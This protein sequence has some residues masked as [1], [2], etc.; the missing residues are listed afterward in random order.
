M[1]KIILVVTFFCIATIVAY[2]QTY[3]MP[4]PKTD[5]GAI[6]SQQIMPTRNYNGTVYEPFSTSTPSEQS[7]VGSSY[8]P[9]DTPGGPRKGKITGPDTPPADES[10]IG[11]P[12][13]MAAF[14]L[15][16]AGTLALRRRKARA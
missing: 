15:L 3:H 11:E 6:Q 10:P 16:F 7:A 13:V 1:K 8:S 14:A 2:A 5:G 4:S 12:W 9:S